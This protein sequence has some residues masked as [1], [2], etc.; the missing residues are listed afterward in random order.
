MPLSTEEMRKLFSQRLA[1]IMAENNINQVELSKILEVSESTVGKWLL[2][3]AMPRM[4]VIQK[5]ADHFHVGKSYFL[6]EAPN[7]GYYTDPEAAEF[8]EYLRTRPGARMLFSAAKDI[9]KE[10]MEETVKYIEF[11]KSK[12]GKKN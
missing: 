5:L 7:E 10:E 3:K 9:T 1:Q 12:H 4:G 8:A 2:E 6:E 11:L